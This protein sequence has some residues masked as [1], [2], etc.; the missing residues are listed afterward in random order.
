MKRYHFEIVLDESDENGR[1]HVITVNGNSLGEC[2]D[3]A[4]YFEVDG[5]GDQCEECLVNEMSDVWIV[6][7]NQII[8]NKF[9]KRYGKPNRLPKWF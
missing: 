2:I 9:Y 8:K 1:D 7:Y 3:K 4:E 6:K 5:D